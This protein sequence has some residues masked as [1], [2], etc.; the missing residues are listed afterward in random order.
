MIAGWEKMSSSQKQEA[1]LAKWASGEGIE[2]AGDEARASYQYR[3]GLIKDAIQLK[4]TPDRVP[5]VPLA[6]FAPIGLY[7]YT[8]ETGYV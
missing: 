7:G 2:F 5:V 8:R 1:F 4:K 3:A 6:I